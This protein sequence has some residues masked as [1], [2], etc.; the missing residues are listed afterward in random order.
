[1]AKLFGALVRERRVQAGKS[2]RTVADA[3]GV[4]HVYL[5]QV[6]RG[7]RRTMPR[8]HWLKLIEAL[9]NVTFTEL[10]DAAARSETYLLD[11]SEQEEPVQDLVVE[12]ARRIGMNSLDRQLA[13]R[14]LDV[15]RGTK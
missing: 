2:L 6:E 3:M 14:L 13:K 12:L 5:A 9:G 11:P 7:E 15:M 8:E 1:M 10:E 4:T